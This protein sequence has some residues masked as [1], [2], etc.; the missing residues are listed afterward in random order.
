MGSSAEQQIL[1]L[2][3]VN[4]M[5]SLSKLTGSKLTD[6]ISSTKGDLEN[7][8]MAEHSDT[9]QKVYGDMIR[10]SDT[11]N[12]IMYYY[13][14]NKDLDN[15]QGAVLTKS[16]QEADAAT[17]DNQ[18]AK[19]QFEVN[20]WTKGNK[21]DTL[22]FLQ[23]LLITFT[24]MVCM[25]FLQKMQV[26]PPIVYVGVSSAIGV[27]VILTLIV[28]ARY[29]ANYRDT[30]YWNRRRFAKM[31]GPPT[32]INCPAIESAYDT[33][34]DTIGSYETDFGNMATAFGTAVNAG[35]TAFSNTYTNV[36]NTLSAS[37]KAMAAGIPT[38]GPPP[39]Q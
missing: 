8:I 20:E 15:L 6:F 5:N 11:T 28:R 14:R 23:L 19:R 32:T 17:F 27:A 18:T 33:I 31:G 35:Q 3:E 7:R 24:L 26:I 4:L 2:Q 21:E 29:T 1:N 10:A 36:Q 25:L 37:Q 30:K 16:T 38:V 9:F 13:V 39:S 34:S 12:N 22:F